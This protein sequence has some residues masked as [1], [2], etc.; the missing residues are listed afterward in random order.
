MNLSDETLSAFLDAELPEAEMER[1][2]MALVDNEAIAERLAEL[3]MVDVM[4]QEHYQAIDQQPIPASTQALLADEELVA[5]NPVTDTFVTDNVVE[6][7][8]WRKAQQ[9]VQ[10]YAAAVAV[11][12]LIAGYGVYQIESPSPSQTNIAAANSLS[13]QNDISEQL[14]HLPSG[15]DTMLDN[16]SVLTIQ[17]S[18]YNQQGELCRQYA[19]QDQAQQS[20]VIACQQQGQWQQMASVEYKS[21]PDHQIDHQALYQTASGGSA[22]DEV[23]DQL[24]ADAPLTMVQEQKALQQL[25]K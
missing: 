20:N 7:P 13:L 2:R 14:T 10:Q 8:W 25:A 23:L 18:F 24:I 5:A 6:F 1:V 19:V 22:L 12:A 9:H 17:L 11:I 21:D 3:A 4:V 15:I 16:D